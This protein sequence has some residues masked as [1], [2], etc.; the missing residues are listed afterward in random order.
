MDKHLHIVTHDIPWPP[1]FGGV[2]DLF[3]KIK[4]LHSFGIKIHLHC[5]F[6]RRP[7]Q[8]TLDKYCESVQ[9]YQRKKGFA[10]FSM[11][12]PYIVQS[13]SDEALLKD[14][15]KDEYPILLEGI[16]CTYLLQ[17]GK[18]KNRK[19]FVRLHNVEYKYY[20]QLAAAETNIFRK[21]YFNL[22]SRLLKKYEQRLAT[23]ANFWAVSLDD[24][25]VYKNEFKAKHIHFL[26]VFLPWEEVSLLAGDG[27]YCLYHGNLSIN[28]NAKAADW[29]LKEVF[30]DI[31][32]PFLIAGKDPSAK[33]KT[34][35]ETYPNSR[36][37]EN[38]GEAEMQDLIQNAQVNILPSF[39]KTGVKL[40]LLNALFNG[41]HCL[42]NA[43]GF[44][45]SGLGSECN[46]AETANEF[47]KEIRALFN[48]EFT[49]E[50]MQYRN[51]A[52]K[53]IYNTEQNTR[54]LIAWIY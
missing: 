38:P 29:L 45:G 16:H 23:K 14:L 20:Q 18:L 35:V 21:T 11:R 6:T 9:Y 33:L 26:P 12:L 7:K 50:N 39:N 43:A 36:I 24:V 53:A 32:I 13:R 28:E 3:Y 30:N 2:V 42:A 4:A 46:I 44:E 15:E 31:D 22:E 25:Q 27:E 54:K 34:L 41:R 49:P 52:L 1:D 17:Q 10:G 8:K 40:K 37:I 51:T 5:F 48:E 19:V 47:K